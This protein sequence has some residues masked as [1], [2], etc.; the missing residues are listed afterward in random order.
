MGC[1]FEEYFTSLNFQHSKEMLNKQLNKPQLHIHWTQ[2]EN[3]LIRICFFL[4]FIKQPF[5]LLFL[6]IIFYHHKHLLTW[7]FPANIEI[8]WGGVLNKERQL[9]NNW[10][11]FIV[12]ERVECS[13]LTG[14]SGPS[15]T[16]WV[17][18]G[19]LRT[20]PL[21][22]HCCVVH[23]L[24]DADVCLLKLYICHETIFDTV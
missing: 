1:E 7:L 16:G 24:H 2:V 15:S 8:F 9:V 6:F 17:W 12:D 3:M 4:L 19:I 13:L 14:P 20:L 22:M 10:G 11:I 21:D 18:T 23:S 5:S